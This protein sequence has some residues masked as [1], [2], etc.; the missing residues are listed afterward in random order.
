MTETQ[1]LVVPKSIPIILL[2]IIY[3]FFCYNFILL[4]NNF[5]YSMIMPLKKMCQVVTIDKI[6]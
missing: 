4:F 3:L 5:N 2:I 6:Y 1:E